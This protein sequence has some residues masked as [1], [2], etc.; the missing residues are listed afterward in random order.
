MEPNRFCGSSF[1]QTGTVVSLVDE[2]TQ[3]SVKRAAGRDVSRVEEIE[4]TNA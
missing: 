4:D 1:S 3:M 2:N